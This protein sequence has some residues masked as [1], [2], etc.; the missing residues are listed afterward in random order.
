MRD[1]PVTAA[2]ARASTPNWSSTQRLCACAAILLLGA[3]PTTLAS[4]DARPTSK[5]PDT[6]TA[7]STSIND[8][9]KLHLIQV[10]GN[11]L[12]EEGDTEGTLK[13]RVKIRLNLEA[14][15]ISATSRFAMYLPGGD[16]L[17]HASGK[18]TAGKGGW[19]SFG[20]AMWIDHGT[21]RYA[22]ASGSGKMYGALNR[23]TYVL[24][25]QVQGTARGL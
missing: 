6:Q 3:I 25:V 5:S 15:R 13:G 18:A 20:G 21:G 14:E 2:L 9:S 10:I 4:G 17:G 23:H 19:E 12:I 7:R 22:H 16:L 8:K 11:T 1:S 24:V